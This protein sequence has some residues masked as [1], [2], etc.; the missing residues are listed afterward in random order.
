MATLQRSSPVFSLF[1]WC[2]V[3]LAGELDIATAPAA[4]AACDTAVGDN[5]THSL[6]VDMSGVTFM[7]CAG[8][9]ALSRARER[10]Q[11][12]LWLRAPSPTVDRI[13]FLT[14]LTG[15]FS[16]LD[17]VPRSAATTVVE[18]ALSPGSGPQ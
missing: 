4:S 8:L 7:D 11:G 10:L 3:V 16:L 9:T 13:L 15:A 18:V 2:L 12:R 17:G 14:G 5:T 1:S 6:V